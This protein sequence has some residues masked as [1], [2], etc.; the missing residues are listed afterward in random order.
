MGVREE[1]IAMLKT[2]AQRTGTEKAL[3]RTIGNG[4]T[5]AQSLGNLTET[6]YHVEGWRVK[7]LA[8]LAI[9][10]VRLEREIKGNQWWL[11]PQPCPCEQCSA[12]FAELLKLSG[13][14]RKVLAEIE[15][16]S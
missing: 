3:G 11:H 1:M 7:R 4:S 8:E 6:S 9:E 2:I 16:L 10:L 14:R 15:K 5:K 12:V 13:Q